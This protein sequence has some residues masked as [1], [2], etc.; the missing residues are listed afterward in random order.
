MAR[1][2]SL[3]GQR[4]RAH[5]LYKHD[6]GAYGVAYVHSSGPLHKDMAFVQQ[7]HHLD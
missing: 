3:L 1:Y 4:S 7:C 2:I 6:H 5:Y